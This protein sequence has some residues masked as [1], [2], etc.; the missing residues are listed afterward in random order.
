MF[1]LTSDGSQLMQ[2]LSTVAEGRNIL[3][4]Q[5]NVSTQLYLNLIR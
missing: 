4:T 3:A 1:E 2:D 5:K